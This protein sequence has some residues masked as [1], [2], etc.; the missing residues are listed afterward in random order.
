MRWPWQRGD[1]EPRT[2]R[3]PRDP[4]APAAVEP[5]VAPAGWA[6]LPPLQRTAGSIQLI[7][8]PDHFT[9]SLASWG[10]PSFTGT[11]THLVSTEAPAG[12]IDVDGGGPVPGS[13]GY[14]SSSGELTLLPPP[15]PRVRPARR[16]R[17]GVP[18]SCPRAR[19]SVR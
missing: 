16:R 5:P 13:A 1:A 10:D 4:V 7:S 19:P 2:D 9:G 18:G 11:M 6:F 14:A 15:A 8:H 17:P 3:A 12:V